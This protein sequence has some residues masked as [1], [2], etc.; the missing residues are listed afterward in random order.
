TFVLQELLRWSKDGLPTYLIC[1][2]MPEIM[3]MRKIIQKEFDVPMLKLT[4]H[5]VQQFRPHLEKLPFYMGTRQRGSNRLE[6]IER[7]IRTAVARYD[8]KAVAFDNI[9]YFVRSIEH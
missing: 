6:D 2:E 3:M 5:H 1:L 9:N 7:T 8:L 4:Q